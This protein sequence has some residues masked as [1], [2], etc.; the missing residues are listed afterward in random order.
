MLETSLAL[1]QIVVDHHNETT[2]YL[3]CVDKGDLESSGD[4]A[5]RAE[6][7]KYHK[8]STIKQ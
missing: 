5:S 8:D 3:W 6:E 7:E 1:C 4:E 2:I